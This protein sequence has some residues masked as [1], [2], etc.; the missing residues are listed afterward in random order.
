M[1]LAVILSS[2]GIGFLSYYLGDGFFKKGYRASHLFLCI[3]MSMLGI[4]LSAIVSINMYNVK[5]TIVQYEEIVGTQY[6]TFVP[7]NDSYVAYIDHSKKLK[8]V[9]INKVK[10]EDIKADT[11]VIQY[12]AVKKYN[13]GVFLFNVERIEDSVAL[14]MRKS[15]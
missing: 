12:E 7:N 15:E 14:V 9:S 1:I 11:L 6:S 10:V 5:E 8:L 2:L 4:S 13:S 3:A